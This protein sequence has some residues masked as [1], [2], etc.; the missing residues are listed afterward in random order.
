MMYKR[1]RI[2]FGITMFVFFDFITLSSSYFPKN[3]HPPYSGD[4]AHILA[5]AK[6][7]RSVFS[8]DSSVELLH[9]E[10]DQSLHLLSVLCKSDLDFSNAIFKEKYSLHPDLPGC[11]SI[12]IISMKGYVQPRKYSVFGE[13]NLHQNESKN[14]VVILSYH[15]SVL[16]KFVTSQPERW[17]KGPL[18]LVNLKPHTCVRNILITL[19]KVHKSSLLQMKMSPGG[20]SI[21]YDIIFFNPFAAVDTRFQYWEWNPAKTVHYDEV[22]PERF[23]SF[24]GYTLQVA[25]FTDDFPVLYNIDHAERRVMGLA[26]SMLDVLASQLNFSYN[27]QAEIPLQLRSYSQNSSIDYRSAIVGQVI[28]REKDIIINRLFLEDEHEELEFSY[29]FAMSSYGALLKMTAADTRVGIVVSPFTTG[30]WVALALS[31]IA[32]TIAF[33]WV[34]K[35]TAVIPLFHYADMFSTMIWLT[36]PLVNQPVPR[37]ADVP[38]CQLI[39]YF[40]WVMALV[41]TT[42]YTSRLMSFVF[43]PQDGHHITSIQQLKNSNRQMYATDE[44]VS[45]PHFLKDYVSSKHLIVNLIDSYIKEQVINNEAVYVGSTFSI[46]YHTSK[47][48][49]KNIYFVQER[50]GA[51]YEVWAFQWGT[52]WKPVIDKY[53]KRLACFGLVKKWESNALTLHYILHPHQVFDRYSHPPDTNSRRNLNLSDFSSS[54]TILGAGYLI[55]S[56][57]LCLEVIVRAVKKIFKGDKLNKAKTKKT[58]DLKEDHFRNSFL[59]NS[60]SSQLEKAHHSNYEKENTPFRNE[61]VNSIKSA[62]RLD[63]ENPRRENLTYSEMKVIREVNNQPFI[64]DDTECKIKIVDSEPDSSTLVTANVVGRKKYTSQNVNLCLERET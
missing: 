53:I 45:L 20:E 50:F 30:T 54:F 49:L 36:R 22:F 64:S 15:H 26:K 6:L 11:P 16:L 14:Q 2:S 40:W 17:T 28:R 59:L 51:S 39:L 3:L 61:I 37:I 42:V 5:I 21:R 13:L 41:L 1:F 35:G 12:R 56:S 34:V 18:L 8:A 29:P 63:R 55:A 4:S 60:S 58:L 62:N 7:F 23:Q 24:H 57:V 31:L 48:P 47:W 33:H 25:S 32:M 9:D 44:A 46:L 52:P 38:G 19:S 10:S 27:L 43:Y